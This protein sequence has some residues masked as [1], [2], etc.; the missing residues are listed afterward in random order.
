MTGPFSFKKGGRPLPP[1]PLPHTHTQT[2]PL[3][4]YCNLRP[5]SA[6]GSLMNH[7]CVDWSVRVSSCY[8]RRMMRM[9]MWLNRR[10]GQL[11]RLTQLT[12]VGWWVCVVAA[13][14]LCKR[15]NTGTRGLRRSTLGTLKQ[16]HTVKL[17]PALPSL[18]YSWV[19][20]GRAGIPAKSAE[21]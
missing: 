10:I 11:T 7:F 6:D 20:E 15:V 1:F 17:S 5:V 21:Q 13:G 16:V 14:V 8:S 19:L 12:V 4:H 18:V 2:N 3:L 9:S